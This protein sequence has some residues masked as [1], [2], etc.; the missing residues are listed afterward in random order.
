[1]RP[2]V[3]LLALAA[4]LGPTA[5]PP[6]EAAGVTHP[7]RES[8]YPEGVANVTHG[9]WA[10]RAGKDVEVTL[11]LEA[12]AAVPTRVALLYCRVEPNYVCTARPP[13]MEAQDDGRTWTATI[14]WD[15]RFMEPETR[16]IGY[17]VT[18]RY[19]DPGSETG[20][21]RVAAPVGNHWVPETFEEGT[22]GVY[23]FFAYSGSVR[24]S[25]AVPVPF[26]I[27]ALAALG[28]CGRTRGGARV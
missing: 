7:D 27:V 12:D 18:M 16:H 5:L 28:A 26:L 22:D 11:T 20:V 4:L 2:F 8:T 1:M 19:V 24:D 13:Q 3:A 21:R 14:P 10:P 25:P 6:M 9:P 15:D 17:N 23:Y